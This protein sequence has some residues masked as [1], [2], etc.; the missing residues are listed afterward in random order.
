MAASEKLNALNQPVMKSRLPTGE[1]I[2]FKTATEADA[3]GLL[4][5]IQKYFEYDGIPFRADE[6]RP[7]LMI[8][9]NDASIGQAWLID[10]GSETAGYVIFT[11]AFDLEF[12]G[13]VAVVTDLYLEPEFRGKGLGRKTLERIE[14]FCKNLGVWALELQVER[15]N[16][17]A[18]AL[19]RKFGF[20]AADRIPMSKRL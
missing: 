12:G 11:Y 6:M 18:Q 4:D 1:P 19:Y 10:C 8:L 14:E 13:R 5:L 15:D 9:L 16:P 3:P 7:G 2:R 20:A 17:E